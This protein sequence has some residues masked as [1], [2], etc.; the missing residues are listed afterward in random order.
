VLEGN[1]YTILGTR[2]DQ[3]DKTTAKAN[4][5][6]ALTAHPDLDAMIGL[7]AYNTPANLEALR[8]A[9]KL[10]KV[11]LVGFDEADGTL[12]GIVDGV[13]YGTVV[14]NPYDYGYKSVVVLD[15]LARGDRSVVPP[16]GVVEVPARQIRR[17]DVEAFWADLKQ[18]LGKQ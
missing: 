16:S 6:D 14:Q 17:A 8:Q 15:A 10:G 5:A 9:G 4:A 11:A 18:K 7:F 1:G 13:V 2:T 12:Q 3:F